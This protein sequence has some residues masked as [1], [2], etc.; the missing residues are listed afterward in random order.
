VLAVQQLTKVS[1]N[2]AGE[3]LKV[4]ERVQER[5]GYDQ[6]VFDVD[7]G[8]GRLL[9]GGRFLKVGDGGHGSQGPT[10]VLLGG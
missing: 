10:P 2:L 9:S 7:G 8:H 4:A 3:A 5:G 1:V 6:N